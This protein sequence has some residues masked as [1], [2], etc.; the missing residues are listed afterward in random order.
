MRELKKKLWKFPLFLCK[1]IKIECGLLLHEL[2][3]G[4]YFLLQTI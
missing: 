1:K 2:H 4:L 3:V